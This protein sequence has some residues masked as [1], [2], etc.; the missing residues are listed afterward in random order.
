LI[1]ER[2]PKNSKGLRVV[3]VGGDV[4]G[5]ALAHCLE[6]IGI[7]YVVLER[8]EEIATQVGLQLLY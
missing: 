4:A 8:R 2:P 7:D 1:I 5:L 3:I 6:R